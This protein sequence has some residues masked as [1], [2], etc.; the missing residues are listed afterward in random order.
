MCWRSFFLQRSRMICRYGSGAFGGSISP[1]QTP[2]SYGFSHSIFSHR[3]CFAGCSLAIQYRH[4][5]LYLDGISGQSAWPWPPNRALC[6]FYVSG[7]AGLIF[8]NFTVSWDDGKALSYILRFDAPSSPIPLAF[9]FR[10]NG[11]FVPGPQR[12]MRQEPER[13]DRWRPVL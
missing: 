10:K 13:Q 5:Q 3:M 11:N 4:D 7:K 2:R 1:W 12:L 6:G 9:P 8:W